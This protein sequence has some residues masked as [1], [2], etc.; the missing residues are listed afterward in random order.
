MTGSLPRHPLSRRGAAALAAALLSTQPG[1]RWLGL[2]FAGS[3]GKADAGQLP[4]PPADAGTTVI[5][6]QKTAEVTTI[7]GNG[8]AGYGDGFDPA[9]FSS[10]QGVAVDTAGN[11]YV[12]D[13][14]N[15]RIR[16]ITPGGLVT[17]LAGD[18]HPYLTNG[19]AAASEFYSPQGVAVD[20]SGNVFV[21]D[22]GDHVIRKIDASGQVTTYAG[23][24]AAPGFADGA[25]A[26]A[27]FDSPGG[28]AID[29]AGNVY[30]ADSGN[31]RIRKID[32][33]GNVTTVA[34]NGVAGDTDGTGGPSGSAQFAWPTGIAADGAGNLFVAD[35][36]NNRIRKIDPEGNV[37]TFA[38]NGSAG[39]ADGSGGRSGSAEL[40][41]PGGVALGAAGDLFVA[42]QDNYR[43][44]RI[45]PSGD[46]TTVAGGPAPGFVDGSSSVARFYGPRAVA[47]AASGTIVVADEENDAI[48]EVDATGTVTTLAGD[49]AAGY[50]DGQGGGSGAIEFD[51]PQGIAVDGYGKIYVADT[52][53][54]RLRSIDPNAGQVATLAGDGT[55]G[56]ANGNGQAGSGELN[57]PV[58]IA[59]G[60]AIYAG[61]TGNDCIREVTSAGLKTM[62]GQPAAGFADGASSVARFSGPAGIAGRQWSVF[63]ADPGNHRIRFV[64]QAGKAS[65]LAGSGAAGTADGP[66]ASATFEFPAAVAV[67]ATGKVIYV[68]DRDANDVRVLQNG[69]VTT[70]AGN[71]VAGDVDGTGGANGTAE[72]NAPQGVA[73][74]SDGNVYVA[75]TGNNRIRQIDPSGNVT[76]LAGNGTA[77]WA[78]GSA[79][80]DGTAEFDAPAGV[81]AD[82]SHDPDTYGNVYVAD[83]GNNRIRLIRIH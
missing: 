33:G 4:E 83:T 23:A 58:G 38:G 35:T 66:A 34:G 81:A 72:F 73:V 26:S 52:G 74:D 9:E 60:G 17:T 27:S 68:V 78:D 24:G 15:H 49:G 77:G 36:G 5:P 30:V 10:P 16:K 76:T 39:F 45:D 80:R 51:A 19:P 29:A 64:D 12:A 21:A 53:N 41:W 71:G 65:T 79:G 44:R 37:T 40:R 61:D 54:D 47:L 42:D 46:V 20:G 13:T 1:C 69:N 8:T 11:V 55:A 25:A 43:L 56:F 28:L 67:D 22:T 18:G 62:S 14:G 63:L 7:A 3:P 82:P 75:D 2:V 32:T 57:H 6:P 70:L 48:R 50:F 31:N 59:F